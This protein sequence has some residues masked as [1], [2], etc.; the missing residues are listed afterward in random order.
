MNY[1]FFSSQQIF[2]QDSG[3]DLKLKRRKSSCW[4]KRLNETE[5][6]GQ[7]SWT[8]FIQNKQNYLGW[9]SL[10]ITEGMRGRNHKKRERNKI[11]ES[12]KQLKNA[13][14][15]GRWSKY[16]FL[17]KNR[18]DGMM[19]PLLEVS[20]PFLTLVIFFSLWCAWNKMTLD[21]GVE[22]DFPH[23]AQ[24]LRESKY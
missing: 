22:S 15:R 17:S 13:V 24:M 6:R 5:I 19:K 20:C 7:N 12:M 14:C 1:S 23:C 4:G 8:L 11:W 18:D 10:W 16:F 3:S 2:P 21:T 9:K